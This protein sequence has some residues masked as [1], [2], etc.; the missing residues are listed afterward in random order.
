MF[1]LIVNDT[2][3]QT[4]R[5]EM[6]TFISTTTDQLR[7]EGTEEPEVRALATACHALLASSRFQILE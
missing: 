5:D 1:E 3:E 2:P 6:V 7:Q 4:E